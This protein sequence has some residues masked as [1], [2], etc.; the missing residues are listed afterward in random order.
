LWS[1]SSSLLVVAAHDLPGR[2]LGGL[3]FFSLVLVVVGDPL[4]YDCHVDQSSFSFLFI[5][6]ASG[7]LGHRDFDHNGPCPFFLVLAT[8]SDPFHRDL[9]IRGLHL[10][11]FGCSCW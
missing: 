10:F 4:N 11:S 8:I 5:V 1:S 7:P 3:H 6:I 9:D 2:D